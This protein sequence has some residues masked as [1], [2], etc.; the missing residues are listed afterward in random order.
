MNTRGAARQTSDSDTA[1]TTSAGRRAVRRLDLLSAFSTGII[2][3][4]DCEC[5]YRDVWATDERLLAMPAN[6]LI[7]RTI[8]EALGE[9]IGR[10]LMEATAR[11]YQTGV[12]EIR[13]YTLMLG[14]G[15][16]TFQATIIRIRGYDEQE[17]WR[18]AALIRDITEQRAIE[19]K[20][21]EAERLAGLGLLAAGVGHEINNPLMVAHEGARLAKESLISLSGGPDAAGAM[22]R[23]PAVIAMLAEVLESVQRMQGIVSDLKLFRRESDDER[24]IVDPL[25]ALRRAIDVTRHQI[26]QR[27]RLERDIQPVP[28]VS[29]TEGKL[30]QIFINLLMNATQ[31]IDDGDPSRN[32]VGVRTST[33]TH[34]SAIVEIRDTGRGIPQEDV[35]RIFDPFFTTK[36]EGMGLGLAICERL[37]KSWGGQIEVESQVGHGTTFRICLPGRELIAEAARPTL[38]AE[39]SLRRMRILL[40]DDEVALLRLLAAQLGRNHEVSTAASCVAALE[41]LSK[42]SRFDAI[43]CD[44]MMPLADGIA[45]HERLGEIAPDLQRRVVFMTGGAFTERTRSFLE[46]SQNMTLEKPFTREEAVDVL[47]RIGPRD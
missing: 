45:F 39:L 44:L 11:V 4:F 35:Q 13:E 21:A 47:S 14:V 15:E 37:V 29:A 18:A 26:E 9:A 2:C 34:G 1:D 17:T 41:I 5:R 46:S 33:D 22:T 43:L 40:V 6:E 16:R 23:I 8:A 25:V 12:P 38:R 19:S 20:L 10:P 27:A 31:A 42:D 7:G 3:E 30:C 32:S 24:S 36:R 28:L